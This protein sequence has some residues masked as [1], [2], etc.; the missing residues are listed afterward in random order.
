MHVDTIVLG[1]SAEEAKKYPYITSMGIYVFRTEILLKLLRWSC[2]S[3]NDFGSEIIPSVV[4][5]HNVQE[6]RKHGLKVSVVRIPKTIDNDIPVGFL[7]FM[8]ETERGRS[9]EMRTTDLFVE[10][11]APLA[12]SGGSAPGQHSANVAGPLRRAIQA[13]P[14]AHLREPDPGVEEA[15]RADDSDDEPSFIDGD[16]DEDSGPVPNQQGGAT[17]KLNFRLDRHSWTRKLLSLL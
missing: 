6:V 8:S 5:D 7:D 12:S 11:L 13:E 16:S 17:T 10:M 4:K 14:E 15:L 9:Q 1:L 3:C 2:S